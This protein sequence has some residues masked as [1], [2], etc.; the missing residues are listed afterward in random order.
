MTAR[1][2]LGSTMTV[3]EPQ[4]NVLAFY[5]GRRTGV[6]AFSDEPNW[7]DDGAYELGVASYAI[8]DGE[9]A[10]VYDTHISISH[11]TVVRRTLEER[12]VRRMQ[13][14]LSHWHLDHIAGNEVFADC[15]IIAHA[16][17]AEELRRRKAKIEAGGEDGQPPICPLILPTRTF[18]DNMALDVGGLRLEVRYVD[19]HSRDAALILIPDRGLLFAG[20]ALE[21]TVTYVGEPDGL[22]RHL[23]DLAQTVTW[24]VTTILPNHGDPEVIAC[25]GYGPGLITATQHYVERLLRCPDDTNLA[26]LKLKEFVADE[27]ARGWIRYFEPYEAVHRLN[28]AA[29]LKRDIS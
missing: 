11:A 2:P 25:G 29:V 26:A 7:V 1:P 15:E 22:E 17:C 12:G 14:L 27:L 24:D 21:D 13:V 8:V 28:V 18:D 23:I 10:V 5:D 6:R 4:P 20:D 3:L 9:E 19:I 16:L